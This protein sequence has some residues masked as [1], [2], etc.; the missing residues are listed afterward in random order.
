MTI[1]NKF[2][3]KVKEEYMNMDRFTKGFIAGIVAAIFQFI[4]GLILFYLELT[5]LLWQDFASVLIYG[6]E[7]LLFGEKLFAE[8]SVWFFSGLMAIVFTY[9]IKYTDERNYLLKGFVFA[10]TV[11]FGTFAITLLFKVP[12]FTTITLKT[13]IANFVLSAFWG[14]LTAE[15]L[16]R[17]DVKNNV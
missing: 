9:L 7:P 10:E 16:R 2:C 12:E 1:W 8:L 11:W 13:S 4:L 6:K 15:L 3:E 17:L 14:M 5:E